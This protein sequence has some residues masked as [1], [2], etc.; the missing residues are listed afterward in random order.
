[1]LTTP[2]LPH[3][4]SPISFDLRREPE[5]AEY[6]YWPQMLSSGGVLP[7]ER[8]ASLRLIDELEG[9]PRDWDGYGAS[10]ITRGTAQNARA[11]LEKLLVVTPSPDITPNPNGTISLE[12]ETETAVAHLEIGVT[13][14][15]LYVKSGSGPAFFMDGEADQ[16]GSD[17]GSVISR[18]VYPSPNAADTMTH[19]SFLM[20]HV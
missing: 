3:S 11:A 12:W 10:P 13:R 15:A 14:F 9:L 8:D 1:M 17:I 16:I 6:R 2:D 4:T 7:A 20:S 18:L 5:S 19:F